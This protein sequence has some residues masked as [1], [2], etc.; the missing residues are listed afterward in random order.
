MKK[1]KMGKKRQPQ[2]K[3][4]K[5]PSIV[6]EVQVICSDCGTPQKFDIHKEVPVI[7]F[8]MQCRKNMCAAI[9]YVQFRKG[10]EGYVLISLVRTDV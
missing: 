1:K 10:T 7:S 2:K 9:Y 6:G 4:S 8:E 3:S 5:E